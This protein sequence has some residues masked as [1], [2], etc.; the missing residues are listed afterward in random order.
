MKA[1]KPIEF[2]A[3]DFR[4]KVD[5]YSKYPQSMRNEFIEYWTEYSEGGLKMRCEKE[6]TFDIGRRLA[7]WERNQKF[8]VGTPAKVIPIKKDPVTEIE[9]LDELL[10]IYMQHPSTIS[11]ETMG[12]SP[13]YDAIKKNKLWPPDMTADE[14]KGIAHIYNNDKPK[15][16]GYVVER[17]FKYYG[18]HGWTFQNTIDLRKQ[19]TG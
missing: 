1:Q 16:R 18:N 12:T 5:T 7:R 8:V 11:L 10:K 2:R 17:T 14:L 3:A 19:R 13:A 15:C 6:T 9:I 4:R